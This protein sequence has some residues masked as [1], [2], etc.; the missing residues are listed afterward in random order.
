[1]LP[2]KWGVL[3][4]ARIAKNSVIP[5]ILKSENSAL[6]AVATRSE[7][8]Q[9]ECRELFQCSRF[10]ND[11]DALLDDPEID[12]VY[13][14]LPNSMHKE[15]AIKAMQKG[16]HVLCEKPMALNA[17]ECAEMIRTAEQNQVLLMEAFMYR[18]TDRTK[19]VKEIVESGE[20]G[21]VRY[22][23][24]TFRFLL[25]RPNT[26]KVQPELGGGSLYDVGSY[27]VNFVGMIMNQLPESCVT[28]CVK[29]NGVDVLFSAL[30]KYPNGVIASISSG[31]NAFNQMNSEIIGTKGR[32]EVPDTFLGS[33]GTIR[34][35]TTEGSRQVP[36]EES[37][38]YTLE[39]TDFADAIANHRKPLVSLEE[40][41]RNMQV[42][43]LLLNQMRG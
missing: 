38:R 16:K 32:I 27:P 36:V 3:G 18:Y 12:A 24:S 6:Q 1:M 34:V 26:I 29:E 21:E 19:K 31:F 40:S 28:E 15:W 25:D 22:I 8:K 43:D 35:V 4:Y 37:D 2:I 33:D 42:I 11:Y 30:L 39:V 9:N 20:I 17:A 7:E 10:Y 13:I 14:P 23:Q 5:A 41:Y